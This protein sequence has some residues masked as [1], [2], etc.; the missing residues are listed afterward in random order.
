MT[1]IVRCDFCKKEVHPENRH[2][3]QFG[4]PIGE[5]PPYTHYYDVCTSCL[6]QIKEAAREMIGY[7]QSK[8][9]DKE[10]HT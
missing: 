7:L 2:L 4:E 5:Y 9:G 6:E 1:T 3:W 8:L 10:W